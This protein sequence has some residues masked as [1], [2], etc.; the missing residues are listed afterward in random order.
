MT[1]KWNKPRPIPLIM[2]VTA[3][4]L[5][6]GLGI[7]QMQRLEWKE[8][9]IADIEKTE[10][11]RPS[12][13]LPPDAELKNHPFARYLVSGTFLNEQEFHLAAR[14]YK[15]VRGYHILTPFRTDDGRII[16]LNRG[17]V[18][19]E[20]KNRETRPESLIEG[21]T[22]QIIRL[23][24][25]KDRNYFTPDA[26]PKDNIWFWKDRKGME[27]YSGLDMAPV[28]ADVLGE[29]NI[30]HLPVPLED[31]MVLRNDHL[32]YALTWFMVGIAVA[33]IFIV[34]HRKKPSE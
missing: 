8:G 7:W 33:I 25:D 27:K 34:Y 22:T 31:K 19:T 12:E 29:Q 13:I 10:K 23:R 20:R 28:T 11:E 5:M 17:W 15:A 21:P 32:G 6:M 16:L 18:P 2:S 24:T 4:L 26:S 9:L 14:D 3:F 30:E 1:S